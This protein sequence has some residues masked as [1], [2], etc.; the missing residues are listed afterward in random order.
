MM[1]CLSG[2]ILGFLL[3][4]FPPAKIFL[5][6]SGSMLLGFL[7][8][9]LSLVGASRKAEAA[10]ALFIPIVAL[11]LPI[12]DT[13]VAIVRRWYKKLPIS[14]PDRRHIHHVLVSMGYSQQRVVLTLYAICLL[15]GGAALVI[16]FA[17][18][19]VVLFVIGSLIAT[20]FVCIR[21]FSGVRMTDVLDKLSLDA[22]HRQRSSEVRVLMEQAMDLMQHARDMRSLW[23]AC[24]QAL[25]ELELDTA[26]LVL[27]GARGSEL[28][29]WIWQRR[30]DP[31]GSAPVEPTDEF[32][33]RLGLREN[34]ELI[35]EL[36]VGKA[37]RP[38][39][40]IPETG[41]LL[42]RLQKELTAH[43]L[44]VAGSRDSQETRPL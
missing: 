30:L 39:F 33:A 27:C 42:N 26:K 6:D 38:G 36:V 20:A 44:R 29:A 4:N 23:A 9:A 11:G 24:T 2:A 17:R 25:E 14:S 35:G 13:S 40:F 12:L 10:V 19:E 8:A 37:V 16:T 28:D 3:F 32:S 43:I 1:A 7:I 31:P 5:G 22:E 41:E 21:I 15:L 34:G 18:S